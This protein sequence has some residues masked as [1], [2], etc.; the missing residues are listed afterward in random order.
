[1]QVYLEAS[2]AYRDALVYMPKTL[3]VDSGIL[4]GDLHIS[5]EKEGLWAIP[6]VEVR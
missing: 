5:L 2:I 1:M 4:S 3:N 6:K